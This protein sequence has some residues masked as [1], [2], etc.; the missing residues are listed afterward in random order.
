MLIIFCKQFFTVRCTSKTQKRLV[1]TA[2]EMY[3]LKKLS[4]K[5][6]IVQYLI[7]NTNHMLNLETLLLLQQKP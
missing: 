7:K 3:A 5:L 4:P 6:F 1:K 2:Q